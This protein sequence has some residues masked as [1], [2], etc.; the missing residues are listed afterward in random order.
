MIRPRF[1]KYE[2]TDESIITDTRLFYCPSCKISSECPILLMEKLKKK[3][4]KAREIE[5]YTKI[6]K[7]LS[8][9]PSMKRRFKKY[10]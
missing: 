5:K 8:Y 3:I 7:A 2:N 4:T 6:K 1:P 10:K 9:I